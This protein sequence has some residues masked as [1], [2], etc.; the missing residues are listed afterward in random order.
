[1]EPHFVTKYWNVLGDKWGVWNEEGRFH[2]L[3]LNKNLLNPLIT[4][5][6]TELKEF[7]NIPDN[8]EVMLVYFGNHIFKLQSFK[9]INISTPVPTFHSRS[10]NSSNTVLFE[11]TLP[12]NSH[13]DDELVCILHSFLYKENINLKIPLI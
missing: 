8:V 11:F 4:K 9:Q 2:V 13:K 7:Y 10:T 12:T 5:G 3:Q 1:M 6:M